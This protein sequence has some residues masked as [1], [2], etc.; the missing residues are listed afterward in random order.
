[1]GCALHLRPPCPSCWG[2]RRLLV[3]HIL[4]AVVSLPNGGQLLSTLPAASCCGWCEPLQSPTVPRTVKRWQNSIFSWAH[5]RCD[6]VKVCFSMD[7]S[8][9]HAIERTFSW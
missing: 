7:S 1:M 5:R 9:L 3:S 2:L 6:V 4:L 8:Y